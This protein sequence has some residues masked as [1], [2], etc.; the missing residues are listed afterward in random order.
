MGDQKGDP[1]SMV[2]VRLHVLLHGAMFDLE[3]RHVTPPPVSERREDVD[4]R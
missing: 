2:G 4:D 3:S 1:M